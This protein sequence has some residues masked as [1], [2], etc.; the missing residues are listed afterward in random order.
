MNAAADVRRCAWCL[1]PIAAELRADAKFCSHRCRQRGWRLSEQLVTDA[2]AA[3]PKR[4][5]YADPPY[6]GKAHL[7]RGEESYGGEVDHYALIAKLRT[8]DGW[9]LSCSSESLYLLLPLAPDAHVCAFV[10]PNGVS[11]ATRGMHSTWEA[12]LVSPAR[13]LRP[14][15]RDWL[16]AKP[17][18][19]GGKLIGRKPLAFCAWLFRCLGARPEL[20]TFDDLFPGT[21][22]VG[23]AWRYASLLQLASRSSTGDASPEPGRDASPEYFGDTSPGAGADACQP[24]PAAETNA[25]QLE[26]SPRARAAGCQPSPVDACQASPLEAADAS[27]SSSEAAA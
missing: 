22:I 16:A 18:R 21:G 20:D 12:L 13:R 17:A 25:C 3:E 23:R 15:F 14:G 26:P 24:S 1:E 2:S 4:L 11:S 6:V 7:Y 9:A 10:K 19:L 8:F 27:S 5:A